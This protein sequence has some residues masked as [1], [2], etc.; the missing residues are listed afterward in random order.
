MSS[1]AADLGVS[2]TE[3]AVCLAFDSLRLYQCRLSCCFLPINIFKLDLIWFWRGIVLFY[4]FHLFHV[5]HGSFQPF[6]ECF[7]GKVLLYDDILSHGE[8][9][10]V[11]MFMTL[12]IDTVS[13]CILDYVFIT[14]HFSL[15]C[16]GSKSSSSDC[17]GPIFFLF[18][19]PFGRA[20]FVLL[21]SLT[22]LSTWRQLPGFFHPL[23]LSVIVPQLA[24][25][26]AE[27]ESS[28]V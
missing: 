24:S 13:F 11:F 23:V 7:S 8:S 21:P 3:H 5:L 19:L 6:N 14:H 4:S 16:L 26:R 17:A 27:M 10:F 20:T 15:H 12:W 22:D 18:H 28:P 2:S 25:T 1:V 9:Q